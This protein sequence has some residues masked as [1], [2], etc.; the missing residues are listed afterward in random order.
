[1]FRLAFLCGAVV[2][3][4]VATAQVTALS[5]AAPQAQTVTFTAVAGPASVVLPELGK[6]IGK[7]L[8]ASPAVANEILLLRLKD[9]PEQE[10]LDRIAKVTNATWSPETGGLRLVRTSV[11]AREMER[12]QNAEKMEAARRALAKQAERV[13]KMEAWD[14]AGARRLGESLEEARKA[15]GD[16]YDHAKYQH[17]QSLDS[18]TPIVRLTHRVAALLDPVALGQLEPGKRIVFSSSPNRLQRPL[19]SA[20]IRWVTDFLREQETWAS[21]TEGLF[22]T[23]TGFGGDGMYFNRRIASVA[24]MLVVVERND[25]DTGGSFNVRVVLGNAKGKTVGRSS[26]SLSA[27]SRT[28]QDMEAL[29]KPDGEPYKITF[30]PDSEAILDRFMRMEPS[31][32]RQQKPLSDA[33]KA[34][35]L[36]PERFDPLSFATSEVLLQASEQEKRNLVANLPDSALSISYFAGRTKS[37]PTQLRR[38]SRDMGLK[39]EDAPGW[40]MIQPSDPM[41]G[42]IDRRALGEFTRTVVARGRST[43][44]ERAA[45][46]LGL[47][48]DTPSSWI[49]FSLVSL[50]TGQ[51]EMM[52]LG[53]MPMLRFYALMTPQQRAAIAAKQPIPFRMLTPAQTALVLDM[54]YHGDEWAL[55]VERPHEPSDDMEMY[56]SDGLESEPT[57]V[58]SNG[59]SPDAYVL[60]TEGKNAIVQPTQKEGLGYGPASPME[61][62]NFAMQRHMASQAQQQPGGYGEYLASM[63]FDR[64]RY[65]ERRSLAFYFQLVPKVGMNKGLNDDT[66]GPVIPFSQVPEAFRAEVEKRLAEYRKS[67]GMGFPADPP[68][69]APPSR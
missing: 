69:T 50:V 26:I 43:L 45:F 62:D 51:F 21:A 18:R 11:Q 60:I 16:D 31:Q 40:M 32:E 6:A 25:Y 20:A 4:M 68:P 10:A 30:S 67:P 63:N 3:P 36:Q 29:M 66:L 59:F 39:I 5:A 15:M 34:K 13:A 1:M 12:T 52:E 44:E 37:G 55:N 54:V 9:V 41:V 65:G 64:V 28:P 35:L 47:P 48:D 22:N 57:E 27:E 61:A 38:L 23:Q 2:A 33:L 46:A 19:P 56:F 49:A 42:R 58:L 14:A 7:N 17:L 53:E 24:K 8:L